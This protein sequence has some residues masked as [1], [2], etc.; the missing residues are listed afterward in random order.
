MQEA[1]IEAVAC[2]DGVDV[3]DCG[4][5]GGKFFLADARYGSLRTALDDQDLN[6]LPS[7]PSLAR[8][9]F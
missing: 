4:R 8:P 1:G 7:C 2:A 3:V 5:K 6:F 9:R